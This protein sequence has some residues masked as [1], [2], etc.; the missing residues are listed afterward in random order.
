[1]SE[2]GHIKIFVHV[3]DEDKGAFFSHLLSPI[4]EMKELKL[5]RD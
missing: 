4:E 3:S 2:S 1:M 5:G